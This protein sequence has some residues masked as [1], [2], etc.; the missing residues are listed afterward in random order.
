MIKKVS[1]KKTEVHSELGKELIK[2]LDGY[3]DV[4]KAGKQHTLKSETLELPEP[5]KPIRPS[6]IKK[7]RLSYNV[8][9]AVFAALLNVPTRTAISWERGLRKP[10]GAALKLLHIAKRRPDVLLSN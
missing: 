9:Q 6:E 1:N 5:V 3:I 4:V 2:S 8:S 10:T 7:I